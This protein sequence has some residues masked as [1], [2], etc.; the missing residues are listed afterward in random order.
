VDFL[1][2][3]GV[4]AALSHLD[5]R[6]HRWNYLRHGSTTGEITAQG[7]TF[8]FHD[9]QLEYLVPAFSGREYEPA[10]AKH[11]KEVLG[12]DSHVFLDIGAYLGYFSAYVG[13]MNPH[14][15]VYAFEPNSRFF[16]TLERNIKLNRLSARA[17]RLALSDQSGQISFSER[18]MEAGGSKSETVTAIPFDDLATQEKICPDVVKV[19]VHGGEGRVLYGMPL[20]L[21]R[22]IHHVYCEIHPEDML[23]G[24]KVRDILDILRRCG[25]ELFEV[26][27]FR[28]VETAAYARLS[29]ER[30]EQ[31]A[32]PDQWTEKQHQSRQM[33]F[34]SKPFS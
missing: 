30:Y 27:G 5:R 17:Y 24:Y 18:S 19:D 8:R 22:D 9:P 32:D 2:S 29:D 16:E 4:G 34:A 1:Y 31:L 28:S 10:V 15:T 6:L 13:S 12:T 33:I 14:C 25:F 26:Q 20:A 23:V 11:M 7:V 21:E 3:I